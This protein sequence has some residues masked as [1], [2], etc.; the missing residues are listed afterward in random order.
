MNINDTPEN[1]PASFFLK[2]ISA[3]WHS[4]MSGYI[5]IVV[6]IYIPLL[7]KQL[8]SSPCNSLFTLN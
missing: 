1:N 2:K 4:E 5:Y 8:R 3:T 6:Y 7:I